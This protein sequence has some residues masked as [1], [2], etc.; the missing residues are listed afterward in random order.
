MASYDTTRHGMPMRT[1]IATVSISGEFPE[2]LA[3]IAKAGFSGV[4]IFENDFLA[5]DASP[6]EVKALAAD[7]GWISR[8]SSHSAISRACRNHT[9]PAPSREHSAS[10]ISWANS[11]PI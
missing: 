7:H 2:K 10:S 8:S 1:S 3:A 4:E 6:R 5:Y 9:A 11:A